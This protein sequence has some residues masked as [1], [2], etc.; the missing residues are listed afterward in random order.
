M[1]KI[2]Q[3]IIS[4]LI[5]AIFVG[6][7]PKA[8]FALDFSTDEDY[9]YQ[10]C[11]KTGLSAADRITCKGFQ[12]YLNKKASDTNKELI[13]IQN[14]IADIR[15]NLVGYMRKVADYNARISNLQKDID[16]LNNSIKVIND[17]IKVLENRIIIRQDNIDS[18]NTSIKARMAAMQGVTSFNDYIDFIFGAKDFVDFIRRAEGIKDITTYDKEQIENLQKEI[19]SLNEDKDDLLSQKAFLVEQK[20]TLKQNMDSLN[21]LKVEVDKIIREYRKEEAELQAKETGIIGNLKEVQKAL[22]DVSKALGSVVPSP[23][24]IYPVDGPF[25]ISAGVWNYP[26][27]FGGGRHIGTDFAAA[28]GSRIVAPGNG[29]IIFVADRCS[30][31]GYYCSWC[32]YPGASGGGNQVGLII[33]IETSVYYILNFH[34]RSGVSNISKVGTVV[35]QGELLGYMGTS[36]CSTGNHLHQEIVYLGENNLAAMVNKFKRTG[37]LS[38]GVG[39]GNTAFNNRCTAKGYKAPCTESALTIYNVKVGRSYNR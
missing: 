6:S 33:Q 13:A 20:A 7:T 17:N 14:D 32:G 21:H 5:I 29:I 30:T 27:S 25:Y 8:I 15:K 18:L 39:W 11:S 23:G 1:K 36:G 24:W 31:N 28:G 19:N 2:K 9:Y 12:A 35:R 3:I 26:A 22:G 38:M 37:D 10:L 16:R 4:I 34:L